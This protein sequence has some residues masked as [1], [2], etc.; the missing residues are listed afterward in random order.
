MK[1]GNANAVLPSV[2]AA[3]LQKYIRAGYLY[4]P[5]EENKRRA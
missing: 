1:Y 3:E 5:A 2:L 4:I